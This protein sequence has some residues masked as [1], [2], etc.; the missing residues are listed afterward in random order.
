MKFDNTY[1]FSMN[2]SVGLKVTINGELG[3]DTLNIV[4]QLEGSSISLE[5]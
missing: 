3:N 2:T 1:T 4:N 5:N